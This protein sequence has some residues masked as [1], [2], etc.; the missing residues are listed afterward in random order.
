MIEQDE[1]LVLSAQEGDTQAFGK[2][3]EK[4]QAAIHGLAFQFVQNVEDA[5]DLAQDAFIKAYINLY[6]LREPA[7]FL[8]W[9]RQIA[10]N[11]CK[12]F[13]RKRE[14][15]ASLDEMADIQGVILM[16]RSI[17]MPDENVVNGEF[18]QMFL[19][20]LMALPADDRLALTLQY[21][22]GMTYDEIAEFIE[23]PKTT[24]IGLLQRAH[25]RLRKELEKLA[26][27]G[28]SSYRPGREFTE[29][30]LDQIS[31]LASGD[32]VLEKAKDKLIWR[33]YRTS[34]KEII[35][36]P[37]PLYMVLHYVN[38]PEVLLQYPITVSDVWFGKIMRGAR[39]G[40]SGVT[41]VLSDSELVEVAAGRF[42]DCL[43]LKTEITGQGV[44]AKIHRDSSVKESDF[45][46][47]VPE[48][49]NDFICGTRLMW[50]AK[51]VGLTQVRYE[52]RGG[53]VTLFQLTDFRHVERAVSP[54]EDDYFPLAVG[55][56]WRYE[57]T[58]STTDIVIKETLT[59]ASQRNNRY[60]F[61]CFSHE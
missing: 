49:D 6:Q 9:L 60:T 59:I 47:P 10:A 58:N 11:E 36:I 44:F 8:S 55:N 40:W 19:S 22:E 35:K 56:T 24:A 17:P 7:K 5:Y 54:F 33:T 20:A 14:E 18:R 21:I 34:G 53:A 38:Q 25:Q 27:K 39:R 32:F 46:K 52:H 1:K 28:L 50:F 31:M 43:L 51:G 29:D 23:I 48:A 2:L 26:I 16:C 45:G 3:V 15:A 13:L 41:T 30:V 12:M 42:S 57:W 37:V 4:Y 61:H